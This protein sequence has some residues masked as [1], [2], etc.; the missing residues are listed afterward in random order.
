MK[1]CKSLQVISVGIN[2]VY[3]HQQSALSQKNNKKKLTPMSNTHFFEMGIHVQ[4]QDK[5]AQAML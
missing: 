5:N 4:K 3:I 1:F 2:A